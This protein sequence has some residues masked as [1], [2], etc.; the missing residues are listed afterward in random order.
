M[1][2]KAATLLVSAVALAIPVASSAQLRVVT[3]RDGAGEVTAVELVTL[4]SREEIQEDL[5]HASRTV[6]MAEADIVECRSEVQRCEADVD[7][8]KSRIDITKTELKLARSQR[9]EADRQNLSQR[10]RVQE[11]EKELLERVEDAVSA[12]LKYSERLLEWAQAAV[13]AYQ[14]ELEF[15][16]KNQELI[17]LEEE[18]DQAQAPDWLGEGLDD[19]RGR[20]LNAMRIEAERDGRVA[21]ERRG[22]VNAQLRVLDAQRKLTATISEPG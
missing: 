15:L 12:R 18:V 11:A 20:V 14:L 4:R 17:A 3:S 10:R 8:Q 22:F 2:S 9:R 5:E 16:D 21:R 13:T 7:I 6:A 1:I 19:L